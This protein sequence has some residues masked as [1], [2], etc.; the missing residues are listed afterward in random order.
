MTVLEFESWVS[1]HYDELTE[2]AERI[3]RHDTRAIDHLHEAIEAVC[4]GR[5]SLPAEALASPAGWLMRVVRFKQM[6]AYDKDVNRTNLHKRFEEE[7]KTL[8]LE[9]ASLDPARLK[10]AAKQRRYRAKKSKA[11]PNGHPANPPQVEFVGQMGSTRWR[12]QTLRDDRLFRQRAVASLAESLWATV[13]RQVH[14]LE[15]GYS[16][17]EFG[18]EGVL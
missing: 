10:A 2:A 16:Y 3:T 13:R 17:T 18:Q 1:D 9:D 8:G 5:V 7:V 15:R 12:Y 14:G 11:S 4:D 6:E